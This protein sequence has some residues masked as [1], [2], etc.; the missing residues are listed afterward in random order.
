MIDLDFFKKIN[1][2]YGHNQGDIVLTHLGKIIRETIREIDI[3][4]RFGG[5]EFIILCPQTNKEQATVLAQRLQK[6]IREYDFPALNNPLKV[7]ASFGVTEINHKEDKNFDTVLER[8]DKALY[9]SK[10]NGRDRV[11]VY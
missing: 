5:E 9:E 4:C 2:S 7:S 11:T 3:P 8:V 10:E 6:Y 1:D